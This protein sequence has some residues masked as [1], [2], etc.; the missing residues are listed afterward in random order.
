M[1]FRNIAIVPST[2]VALIAAA[3]SAMAQIGGGAGQNGRFYDGH[4][5]MWGSTQWGG[6]GMFLGPVFMILIVIGIVAGIVYLLRHFGGAGPVGSRDA[7]HDQALAHLKLRYAKG[8]ID[9][10]EFA[11]RKKL[12][13]D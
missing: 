5:M 10:E 12:L 9:S 3:P 1:E 13:A 4:G 6:F 11:D 7:A 8:E 2:I